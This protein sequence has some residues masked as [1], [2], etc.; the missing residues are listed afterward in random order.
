MAKVGVRKPHDEL[1]AI[2]APRELI[3][4]V[5]KMPAELAARNAWVDVPR[6]DWIPYLAVVRG[7]GRETILRATCAC[8]LEVAGEI[9]GPEAERVFGIL[10]GVM[11][12]G[13]EALTT[14]EADLAD[15]RRVIIATSHRTQ[16]RARPAWMPWAE[17]VFELA[18]ASSRG[19]VLV[20]VALAMRILA[21]AKARGR[22]SDRPAHGDLVARF[23]DQ[24]M[25]VG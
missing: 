16:P 4:W 20:G 9:E 3:E 8:A 10:R 22:A 11:T 17:L 18:R 13:R 24:V 12:S 19:N 14:A 7:I 5:R 1:R 2:A 6:A 15:L 23:R 25:L 21:N